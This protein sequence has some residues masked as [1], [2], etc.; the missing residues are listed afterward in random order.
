MLMHCKCMYCMHVVELY[1]CMHRSWCIVFMP[2]CI[3]PNI[4]VAATAND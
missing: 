4:L 2:H 3:V 1:V